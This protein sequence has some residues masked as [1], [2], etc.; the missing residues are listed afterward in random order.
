VGVKMLKKIEVDNFKS[1]NNFVFKL[2]NINVIIGRN[3]CGK[4]TILQA[5]DFIKN[6]AIKD[7]DIY[8]EEREWKPSELKSQFKPGGY[9]RFEV[10]YELLNREIIIWKFELNPKKS[11]ETIEFIRESIIRKSDKKTLME[12]DNAKGGKRYNNNS[13]SFEIIPTMNFKSSILKSINIENSD[14]LINYPELVELKRYFLNSDSFELMA[15]DKMRKN[16]RGTADSIGL[17]GEKISTFIHS[18]KA[19]NKEELKK[20]LKKYF[21]V[22]RDIKTYVKGKPGWVYMDIIENYGSKTLEIKQSHISDGVLRLIGFAAIAEIEKKEGF[23]LLDEI[24]DGIS[25]KIASLVVRDLEDMVKNSSRQLFVTTHSTMMMDYF[26]EENVIFLWRDSDGAV[27]NRKI[28]DNSKLKKMLNEMYLGE[29]VN[30]LD[31][32]TIIRYFKD[33]DSK[34]EEN[35]N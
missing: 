5:L 23:V 22:S 21:N 10:E 7:L 20:M 13:G 15:T 24:E 31:E 18:M 30:V 28:T 29:L 1:L 25:P 8:L 35:T 2:S 9:I 16:S 12:Y 3:G 14:N 17:G 26:N 4:T 19:S 34:N 27:Y 32:E 6:F 11:D 33:E